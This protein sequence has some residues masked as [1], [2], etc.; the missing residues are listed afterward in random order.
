LLGN[1][2]SFQ[3]VLN[4][5]K[6][7]SGIEM[8][9]IINLLLKLTKTN[10]SGVNR[11]FAEILTQ[12]SCQFNMKLKKYVMEI[13]NLCDTQEICELFLHLLKLLPSE[14]SI[15]LPVS[16]LKY[17]VQD[18]LAA[19]AD[20]PLFNLTNEL[21]TLAHDVRASGSTDHEEDKST[22]KIQ[23]QYDYQEE[24]ILP[25]VIELIHPNLPQL[26]AN[27]VEGGYSCW[28]QYYDTQFRLLREDFVAPLR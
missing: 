21:V 23:G 2:K 11:L 10:G 27:I 7:W 16:D 18:K 6:Q 8:K 20:H 4:S 17:V 13:E 14:A 26:R 19:K 9:G 25:K 24:Q 12:R 28:E 1:L 15:L 3:K 5:D 22:A